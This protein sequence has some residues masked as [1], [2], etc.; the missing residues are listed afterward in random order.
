MISI[1]QIFTILLIRKCFSQKHMILC[2]S[3]SVLLTIENSIL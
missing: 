2:T 1:C 3:L